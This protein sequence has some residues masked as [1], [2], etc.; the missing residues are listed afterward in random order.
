[1]ARL[2]WLAIEHGAALHPMVIM[3]PETGEPSLF[4]GER[5]AR[6]AGLAAA[7]SERVL[8][9]VWSY[10]TAA[11]VTLCHRWQPGDVVLWNNL[12]VLHRHDVLP[13][14]AARRLQ[15]VRFKGRYTLAAP[16]QQEAA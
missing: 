4:L 14:G 11:S 8:N 13:P 2:R 16:I 6:I 1:M 5:R 15:H 3:Q 9:I 12:T 10:A 7:E